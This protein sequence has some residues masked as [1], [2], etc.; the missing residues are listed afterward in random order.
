MCS[1]ANHLHHMF[2]C[3]SLVSI[4]G[5]QEIERDCD[6]RPIVLIKSSLHLLTEKS[7]IWLTLGHF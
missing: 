4:I 2:I 3:T 5:P 1:Q 6:H 7:E